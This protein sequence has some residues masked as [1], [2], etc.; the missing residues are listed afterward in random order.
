MAGWEAPARPRRDRRDRIG[1]GSSGATRAALVRAGRCDLGEGMA[2]AAARGDLA[3][4]A[5]RVEAMREREREKWEEER[6][7]PGTIPTY[8]HRANTSADDH[9]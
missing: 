7:G 3:V 2:G 8:V 1:P 6:S 5:V 9:K 4:A